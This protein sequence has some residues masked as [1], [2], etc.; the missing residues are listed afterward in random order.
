MS[1]APST[2]T[3]TPRTLIEWESY[4][5]YSDDHFRYRLV[6]LDFALRLETE[7]TAATA[8]LAEAGK[9]KERLDLLQR[10]RDQEILNQ[11]GFSKMSLQVYIG[12]LSV[13]KALDE[14]MP[15]AHST[16]PGTKAP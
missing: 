16:A 15:A 6:R 12:E 5:Q 4:Q 9:D 8:A 13:R 2:G 1:T 3:P 11:I 14:A 7:L 10:M